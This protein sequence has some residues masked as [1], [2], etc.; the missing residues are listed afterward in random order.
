MKQITLS[1]EAMELLLVLLM[2]NRDELKEEIWRKF[3][4]RQTGGRGAVPASK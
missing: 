3:G 1:E 4:I 2:R